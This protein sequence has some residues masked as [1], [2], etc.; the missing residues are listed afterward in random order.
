M[1]DGAFNVA[2]GRAVEFYYRVKSNDPVNS[3][4]VILLLKAAEADSVLGDYDDLAALLGAAGN[5]EA[6][7]TNYARKTLTDS[8]LEPLPAPDDTNNR[9]EIDLPNQPF[10]NAGGAVNNDLVKAVIA[11]DSDSTSGNDS[12]VIPI[13]HYDCVA[14]TNGGDILLEIDA[15]G[16]YRAA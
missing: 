14:T 5:T 9:Y 15:S 1:G 13:A 7:F 2:K 8:D 4:L 12:G 16:F 10:D 11:Y 6:D 3:A